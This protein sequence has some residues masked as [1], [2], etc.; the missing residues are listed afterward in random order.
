MSDTGNTSVQWYKLAADECCK[1]LES[2]PQQGLAALQITARQ[3][4]HGKNSLPAA[5]ATPGWLRFLRQFNNLLI[6]VLLAA[7]IITAV[8]GE[9]LDMTV[10]LAVILANASIGFIQEGRAE[11]ALRAIQ[12][13]LS[14]KA[15]VVR[16]GQKR[17]IPAAELV[18]GD[19][20]WLEAGD[21]VPADLRLLQCRNLQIQEAT[22]TGESVPVEKQPET[23]A[24]TVPLA[25]RCNCA[26]SGT[27]VTQGEGAGVAVSTGADTEIGRINRLLSDV[28]QIQT[29]LLRQMD[30]FARYMAFIIIGLAALVFLGGLWQGN[31]PGYL[32]MVVVSLVVSA[33][34]EGLPTIL[35]VALAIGVTRM[36]QRH[37]II[38]KLPA[39]ETLG[40]VSVICSDKT[41]TLTRNE[42]MVAKV[43]LA[44]KTLTAEGN[45]YIPEGRFL[46]AADAVNPQQEPE[47][48]WLCRAVALCNNAV[49][50][51]H[52]GQ[53]IPEGD[54]ME[55]ALLVL[56][57]K[58]GLLPERLAADNPRLDTIPF[59]SR[60][61]YMATLHHDENRAFIVVKGAPEALLTLCDS[62]WQQAGIQPM[63]KTF[64]L[65]QIDDIA[66]EGQ[67]VLA[68]AIK[69]LDYQPQ[70]QPQKLDE[71]DISSGLLLLGLTGLIDPPRP[72][73]IDAIASCHSA[74]I[75]VKMI[76]GDHGA[77][78]LAIARQLNLNN[79]RVVVTGAE[80]DT[81]SDEQLAVTA[82]EADVFARTTPEHKLRL[83]QALQAHGDVVA[84]TG[85]GVND[86]PA[87]KRAD[88]GIAMGKGGTEAA[89]EA[90][91][92][93][94]TDDNFASIANAVKEGRTV[95]DNLKKAIVFMLPINGGESMAVVLAVLFS[96]T[97]PILPL[98]IL[99][100]NMVGSIGLAMTLAFEASEED[101]MQRKPR[102]A[103]EPLL[104]NFLLWRVFLV[105][106]LFTAGIFIVFQWAL[107]QQLSEEYARTMAVNTLIA[108]EIWYLFS[109]R[110]LHGI[111]LTWQGIK[112]TGP[113]L[114]AVTLVF[115]LQ[116]CFTYVPVL[117]S[118]FK[119][120][121]ISFVHGMYCAAV[122]VSVFVILELE[123][124]LL[125][126]TEGYFKS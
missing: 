39:T 67:R 3:T 87:L 92:M 126:K 48:L 22:L 50:R 64:W 99:W 26:Y 78:A 41:G 16:D 59:D 94:L 70:Y 103:R 31:A 79:T 2:H 69:W 113:V 29:P 23:L 12:N 1:Q 115:G 11:K 60:H 124:W 57:Y 121:A 32:F 110:Y 86:A 122:G 38:R 97:L 105:S 90:S 63:D 34:P 80:L 112:G 19:I 83:V 109:V 49:L 24:Q 7:A 28:E 81:L 114:I 62:V 119:T 74:G 15:V 46:S 116:L 5:A 25:E 52:N 43:V 106:V 10:I 21:K 40:V 95:Y 9:W 45:G 68:V 51:K 4:L 96:L 108:M 18:P 100:V 101:V 120:E 82:V 88:V 107:S 56:G 53:W 47:L 123:K 58:A 93:V 85:D 73:V 104:S 14:S 66:A 72:E 30:K 125:R 98:Q 20:V 91:E 17:E 54:P 76:T 71:S 102:A 55:A 35:T 6:M 117:Q 84:M 65:Q 27:L 37:A 89:R 42:M 13:M 118:L 75:R 36:A 8:I 111:S 77:T 33:I 61:K 44:G